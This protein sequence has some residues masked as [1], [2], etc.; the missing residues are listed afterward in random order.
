MSKSIFREAVRGI[1]PDQILD[2][3]IKRGYPTPTSV[4]FAKD[5][6]NYMY[7]LFDN[8]KML[9]KKYV[10]NNVLLEILKNQKNDISENISHPLW[11]ALVLEEWLKTNF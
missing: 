9:S 8:N 4:W 1:V 5:L 11:Q 3:K 10:N 2:N 7:N 6:H